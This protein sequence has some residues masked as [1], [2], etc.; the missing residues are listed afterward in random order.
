MTHSLRLSKRFKGRE[1]AVE[2]WEVGERGAGP[3]AREAIVQGSS[4]WTVG[5]TV[6]PGVGCPGDRREAPPDSRFGDAPGEDPGSLSYLNVVLHVAV[7][8]G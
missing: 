3:G 5:A 4:L 6:R 1:A 2:G 7:T 8:G